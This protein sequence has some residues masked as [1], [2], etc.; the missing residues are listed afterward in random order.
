MAITVRRMHILFVASRHRTK[1][2]KSVLDRIVEMAEEEH[3]IDN[4]DSLNMLRRFIIIYK[5]ASFTHASF[6]SSWR[7]I[8]VPPAFTTSLIVF[9][10]V[11]LESLPNRQIGSQFVQIVVF[12][13]RVAF[14]CE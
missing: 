7:Q 1:S 5:H 2:Q 8:T 3:E 6:I 14:V 9:A 13:S 10:H 11:V 4:D 12:Q